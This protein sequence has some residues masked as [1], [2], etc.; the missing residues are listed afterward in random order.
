LASISYDPVET[1]A[2]FRSQ[3]GTAFPMLSDVGSVV[4][5]RFGILNPLPE[6]ALGPDKDDPEL[7]AE[8]RKY[9]SPSPRVNLTMVGM[10]EALPINWGVAHRTYLWGLC[11]QSTAAPLRARSKTSPVRSVRKKMCFRH[12]G[13]RFRLSG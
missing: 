11:A 4:N 5:K 9:V 13:N 2:A 10:M 3:H 12:N 1:L 7:Q 8:L 6:L